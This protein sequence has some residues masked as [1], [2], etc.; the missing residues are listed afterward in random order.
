MSSSMSTEGWSDDAGAQP[1]C[2]AYSRRAFL[3]GAVGGLGVFSRLSLAA[4]LHDGHVLAPKPS[5]HPPRARQLL[6]VFLTGGFSHLDTFDP[7]PRLQ[8]LHDKPLP[9][10]GLRPD[11][12]RPL[13][14][15]RSPFEFA[16]C[17]R[18]GLWI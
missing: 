16:Q 18:S 15:L 2:R 12:S 13:P 5:H 17:G 6:F 11:E 4:A 9:A 14:L 3:W 1:G 10:F 7:K 8:Q